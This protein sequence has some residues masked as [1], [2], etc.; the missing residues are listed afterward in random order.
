MAGNSALY[1]IV[2]KLCYFDQETFTISTFLSHHAPHNVCASSVHGIFTYILLH[3][4]SLK[5]M[6]SISHCYYIHV[7]NDKGKRIEA[8]VYGSRKWR[9]MAAEN[10]KLFGKSLS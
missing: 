8:T 4:F 7:F 6:S 5:I 1:K 3:W 10:F 2:Y 9:C